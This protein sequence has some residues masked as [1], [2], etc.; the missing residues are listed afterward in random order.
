MSVLHWLIGDSS[1]RRKA[2]LLYKRGMA[3]AKKHD[4]RGAIDD[5]TKT[6]GMPHTPADVKAMVLYN[7]ALVHVTVGNDRQGV[8]DLDAVLAMDQAPANIKTMARQKR[9]RDEARHAKAQVS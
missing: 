5:Y 2:L 7:R 6:L 9:L 4:Y 8:D 1:A 3:K